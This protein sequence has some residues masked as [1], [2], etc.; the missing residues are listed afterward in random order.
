MPGTVSRHYTLLHHRSLLTVTILVTPQP[1]QCDR[2]SVTRHITGESIPPAESH[3]QVKVAHNNSLMSPCQISA[4]PLLAPALTI[5]S[6]NLG[7]SIG[8]APRLQAQLLF[9]C[10]E[11]R[12]AVTRMLTTELSVTVSRYDTTRG[13]SPRPHH[14]LH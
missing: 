14:C 3:Y 10:C 4:G 1:G 9:V 13:L 8:S 11:E 7:D 6:L 2:W 12:F 5:F